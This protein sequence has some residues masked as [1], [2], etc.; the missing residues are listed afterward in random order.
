MSKNYHLLYYWKDFYPNIKDEKVGWLGTTNSSRVFRE[1][2]DS[3]SPSHD[4]LIIAFRWK[5]AN[6]ESYP[7]AIL[8]AVIEP[9]IE[10]KPDKDYKSYIYY[11]P[12]Q[13]FELA[14]PNLSERKKYLE[15]GRRI[16]SLFPPS[17]LNANFNGPNGVQLIYDDVTSIIEEAKLFHER[18]LSIYVP[19]GAKLPLIKSAIIPLSTEHSRNDEY[20]NK[21]EREVAPLA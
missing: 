12:W 20:Q 8:K 3:L 7:L 5:K 21:G 4:S 14:E 9:V 16:V 6:E 1:F 15:L 11:D 2:N 17:A 10:I 13:S 18:D 19:R